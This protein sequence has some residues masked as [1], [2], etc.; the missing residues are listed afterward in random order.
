MRL[1]VGCTIS[2]WRV[3]PRGIPAHVEADSKV[4]QWRAKAESGLTL[5]SVS[6]GSDRT[7]NSMIQVRESKREREREARR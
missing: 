3:S 2:G 5:P 4:E 1:Y 6:S 7:I